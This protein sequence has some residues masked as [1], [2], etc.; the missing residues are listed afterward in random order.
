LLSIAICF[1]NFSVYDIRP[2][3]GQ[4]SSD[5]IYKLVNKGIT[6]FEGGDYEAAIRMYDRA[7][8]LSPN[9]TFAQLNKDIAIDTMKDYEAIIE[10]DKTLAI[11]PNDVYA[12]VER[13]KALY[14]IGNYSD[15][16]DSFDRALS[17]T[18]NDTSILGMKRSALIMN[19]TSDQREVDDLVSKGDTARIFGN[20][21]G[22]LD[23]Y[24]KALA[25]LHNDTNAL[26]MKAI[27]LYEMGNYTGALQYYYKMQEGSEDQ[28]L[29]FSEIG[30][31]L[32]G[33]G[34][35]TGALSYYEKAL[36]FYPQNEVATEGKATILAI[37]N[38]I[39]ETNNRQVSSS[40]LSTNVTEKSKAPDLRLGTHFLYE[41]EGYTGF[42]D[43]FNVNENIGIFVI[44]G[45]NNPNDNIYKLQ[46]STPNSVRLSDSQ[47]GVDL[48][49][50]I[51]VYPNSTIK[52]IE[53]IEGL[54]DVKYIDAQPDYKRS[55]A[56]SDSSL[57]INNTQ[58]SD[59]TIEVKN[60]NN[61]TGYLFIDGYK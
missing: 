35:Y 43:T 1:A 30:N 25:I 23:Y 45:S 20:Y 18:P 24:D 56:F 14:R 58:Y 53:R 54:Y 34:N 6:L 29:R 50:S 52:S 38:L 40:G 36:E 3:L 48:A 26:D 57:T 21:T 15:A 5:E 7:L 31:V 37:F 42:E 33:L 39:N 49:F 46:D 8:T 61:D 60:F 13:G 2:V 44:F 19:D 55:I 32:F 59:L 28:R 9:H 51:P 41:A 22:A 47:I 11:E 12:L 4:S 16:S 17:V 27:T 10:Y